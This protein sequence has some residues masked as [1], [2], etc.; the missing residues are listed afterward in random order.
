MVCQVLLESVARCVQTW[1]TGRLLHGRDLGFKGD[2]SWHVHLM[3]VL[4]DLLQ[5][6]K[7]S[8]FLAVRF[9][10]PQ[11]LVTTVDDVFTHMRNGH[12]TARNT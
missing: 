9:C 2:T 8:A 7:A 6:A 4:Q 12:A 5:L 11:R 1:F 3:L 10:T